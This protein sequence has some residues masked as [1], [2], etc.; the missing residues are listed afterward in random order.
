MEQSNHSVPRIS[1][2][3][4]LGTHPGT[5]CRGWPYLHPDSGV[6]LDTGYDFQR[7]FSFRYSQKVLLTSW[8]R[9]WCMTITENFCFLQPQHLPTKHPYNSS[10]MKCQFWELAK[11]NLPPPSF[12]GIVDRAHSIFTDSHLQDCRGWLSMQSIFCASLGTQVRSLAPM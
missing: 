10:K 6:L 8:L 11:R 4:I 7:L 1:M 9:L 12:S 3:L 5:A 2:A